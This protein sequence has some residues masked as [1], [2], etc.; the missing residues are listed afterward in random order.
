MRHSLQWLPAKDEKSL[1]LSTGWVGILA[2]LIGKDGKCPP[3]KQW[4][5][6]A[7]NLYIGTVKVTSP[8]QAQRPLPVSQ[9]T[10]QSVGSSANTVLQQHAW[11][12]GKLPHGRV[13]VLTR[14][15]QIMAAGSIESL[16]Y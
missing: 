13:V 6:L 3:N 4:D 11:K 1:L 10:V 9:N 16:C 7:S 8:I 15:L 5:L 14:V 12:M 2:D